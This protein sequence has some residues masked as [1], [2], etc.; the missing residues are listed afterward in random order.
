MQTHHPFSFS[1][2][3]VGRVSEMRL[4]KIAA[5]SAARGEGCVITV[6]G[7][8]GIGKTCL[9]ETFAREIGSDTR[10]LEGH[11][12][13]VEG[14]PPYF[15]WVEIISSY[16]NATE[17]AMLE[18]VLGEHAAVIAEVVPAV[19]KALGKVEKPTPLERPDSAQFRFFHS[20][21]IVLKEAA[22]KNGLLI[23]LH[24]LHWVDKSSAALLGY[25]LGELG[26]AP[27]LLV[28][29]YRDRQVRDS[30]PLRRAVAEL[31]R[32]PRHE[33]IELKGLTE[34][35]VRE[36]LT[37]AASGRFSEDFTDLIYEATGGVPLFVRELAQ[38][39]YKASSQTT[40]DGG[41]PNNSRVP[42]TIRDLIEGWLEQLSPRCSEIV[43]I[44]AGIG[45]DFTLDVLA[46]CCPESPETIMLLMEEAIAL[47]LIDAGEPGRFHFSHSVVRESIIAIL[48]STRFAQLHAR[49]AKSLEC[50]YGDA[51]ADNAARLVHHFGC[52]GSLA[53]SKGFVRYTLHAGN[54][55]VSRHAYEDAAELF[56]RALATVQEGGEVRARLLF[57]LARCSVAFNQREEAVGLLTEAFDL[58]VQSGMIDEAVTA[59]MYPFVVPFRSSGIAYLSQEALA[60][61]KHDS[62]EAGKL[63]C[64]RGL[65]L[66]Q[67]ERDYGRARRACARGLETARMHKDPQLEARSLLLAAFIEREEQNLEKSLKRSLE[68]LEISKR[69]P[70]L[71]RTT[72]AHHQAQDALISSGMFDRGRH[73]AA[74]ELDGAH[75]LQDRYLL[76]LAFAANQ[77][78]QIA[79]GDWGAARDFSDRGLSLEPND[80]FLLANRAR[81]EYETGE[82]ETGKSF[83]K[84][85]LARLKLDHDASP[86]KVSYQTASL[87]A[88]VPLICR[89]VEGCDGLETAETAARALIASPR[90]SAEWRFRAA[91]C[92]GL[93]A[94]IREDASA[95]EELYRKLTK[96][97]DPEDREKVVFCRGTLVFV[98]AQLARLAQ[99]SGK[100]DLAIAHFKAAERDCRVAEHGPE[101]AWICCDYAKTLS[102]VHSK[103]EAEQA[104]ALL[105]EGR[106]L[107]DR[108]GMLPL[109][110]MID[111]QLSS[112]RPVYPGGLTG[113]E[114]EVLRLIARGF[115]NQE[116]AAER[117]IADHTAANHVSNILRKLECDNRVEAA[118]FAFRHGL[119]E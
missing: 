77:R 29:S 37:T 75:R 114:I 69:I 105:D 43:T 61:V 95:A 8:P 34:A 31:A 16:I 7:D 70:D 30:H 49:I 14:A 115:T 21:A 12:S 103:T 26:K 108:F 106:A 33:T 54:Q 32:V 24:D 72:V 116:I 86:E 91:L 93:I 46:A 99:T 45:I 79:R 25:I 64:Q 76:M 48:P 10:V 28:L 59:A 100:I 9:L 98:E 11:C 82:S 85:Y 119:I 6:T 117:Y 83:L 87:A 84:R 44:A 3:F 96:R 22:K 20:V 104:S 13:Y 66:A 88:V 74:N 81:L 90:G 101:L 60:L 18:S 78:Y 40:K 41:K 58:F 94:V 17:P 50:Y 38:S 97:H 67:E 52:A 27:L 80:P 4:L 1:K 89:T 73:H 55:A 5:E 65:A 53:V 19:R 15:P 109:A 118:A 62:L 47:S 110:E 57:G 71:L 56:K 63:E 35:E 42:G 112:I 92:L 2:F 107:A 102:L 39:L 111:S 68:A 36:L 23:I 51:A 113:T